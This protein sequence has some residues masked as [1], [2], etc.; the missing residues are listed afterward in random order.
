MY[1]DSANNGTTLTTAN[2]RVI[3]FYTTSKKN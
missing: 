2:I 1:M 3:L